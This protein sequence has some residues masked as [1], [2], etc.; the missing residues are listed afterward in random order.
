MTSVALQQTI[1]DTVRG[2]GFE[3]VETERSAGGLLRVSID[4]PWSPSDAVVHSIT[5]EDCERVTR[6]LQYVLEVEGVDY[7]RLEVS[8]PGIDRPLRNEL[9][10]E[11]FQGQVVDLVLKAPLGV[12]AAA[13]H[14]SANR[15]KFRG[16]LQ[17]AESAGWQ[18][19]WSDEVAVKPGQ[20]VSAKRAP[21]PV[22]VMAF[23][24]DE[25]QSARLAP[26]VDF[27]GRGQ[28]SL[29]APENEKD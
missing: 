15:K 16:T 21:P 18:I 12:A 23:A 17:R 28:S 29:E 20:R 4:I 6:Q 26:M 10:F 22:N 13:G 9:D 7:K 1:D 14:V 24:L 3:P 5:V 19:I 27:K 8:S 2:L 11:R 25:L